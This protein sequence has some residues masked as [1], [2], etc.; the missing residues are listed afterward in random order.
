MMSES[1]LSRYAGPI[2]LIVGAYLTVAH[3]ALE[4]VFV[5]FNDVAVMV[6]DP[7]IRVLNLGYAAAFPGLVIAASLRTTTF[8][9][10]RR[11][12]PVDTHLRWR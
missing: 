4:F 7:L 11:L 1:A 10:G 5:S 8:V 6:A 3:L 9:G 12:V 2:V